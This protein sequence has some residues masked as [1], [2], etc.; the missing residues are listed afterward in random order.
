MVAWKPYNY[1]LYGSADDYPTIRYAEVLLTYAEARLMTTGYDDQVRA[2]LNQLR[3]RCGMPDVPE[4]LG[5]QEAINFLRNERRIELAVEGHRFDDV[6]R[7]GSD[8]CKEYLNG[9]STA[10]DGS[11]V[12]NKTWNDRLLL[13]PIPTTAIDVN[14]LLK[15]DQNPGY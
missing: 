13:M 11:V 5:K 9:P 2:A 10:P 12:V 6:R 1:S 3:D 4:S 14:P 15:D 7:Y 8:Y